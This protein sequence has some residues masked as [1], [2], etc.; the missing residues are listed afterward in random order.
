MP[1]EATQRWIMALD[2]ENF[3]QRRD[4]VQ[5]HVRAAMYRVLDSAMGRAGLRDEYILSED[6]GDG[7]LML[8][9]PAVSPLLIVGPFVR[10]LDTELGEYAQGSNP[11]HALRLRL[12]LHQGLA[13]RDGRGWSGDAVNTTCR[14]VDAQPLR[15]VLAAAPSARMV[16]AVSDEVHHSVI[17]HGHRG[18]DPAAYL[19]SRFV[20]KHGEEIGLWATVP[21]RAAPPGLSSAQPVPA[22]VPPGSDTNPASGSGRAADRPTAVQWA[23]TV[24][25]DQVAGDKNV[26]VHTNGSVRL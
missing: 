6:R 22:P 24:Q 12:T 14:L 16:F 19:P 26:T 15:D 17:R 3:S 25:G 1:E 13:T 7:V 5:R 18:I 8:V 11:E 4:P 20:T 9:D 21:G 23:E 10:E 2:I